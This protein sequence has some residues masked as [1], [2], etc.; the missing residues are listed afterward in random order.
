MH[1]CRMMYL[2]VLLG[3]TSEDAILQYLRSLERTLYMNSTTAPVLWSDHRDAF[4]SGSMACR[5]RPL[6]NSVRSAVTKG[7]NWIEVRTSFER[8][9][10]NLREFYSNALRMFLNLSINYQKSA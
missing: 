9:S 3:L 7:V 4:W 8:S 1:C 5:K 10:E 6:V 2:L